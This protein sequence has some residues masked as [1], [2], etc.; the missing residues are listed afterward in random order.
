MILLSTKQTR[1]FSSRPARL[2][3]CSCSRLEHLPMTVSIRYRTFADSVLRPYLV[4][5]V[6]GINDRSGPIVGLVDSGA[7]STMFPFTFATLMGY[8]QSTLVQIEF[9]QADGSIGSAFLATKPCAAVVPE[10]A[11]ITI[12]MTP[13]FV[14]GAD[15]TLWGS[16][17]CNEAFRCD[18][19]GGR[20]TLHVGAS[21]HGV[22]L[23]F[24]M[25]VRFL[26]R[27][28]PDWRPPPARSTSPE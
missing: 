22:R 19:Q 18:L 23:R 8:T 24:L 13:T 5:R 9:G 12:E 7:D 2:E 20:K 25:P 17:R 27:D 6:T 4:M 26:T 16:K 21:P 11:T 1:F 3:L 15:L 10:V 14:R 28:E